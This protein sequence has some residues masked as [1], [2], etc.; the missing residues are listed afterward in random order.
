MA[1]FRVI[2][3]C[4]RTSRPGAVQQ[5]T[6]SAVLALLLTCAGCA[7]PSTPLSPHRAG[8]S[9]TFLYVANRLSH[10]VTEYHLDPANGTLTLLG[11]IATGAYPMALVVA[12]QQHALYV[13][14][15]GSDSVS[16][17]HI[18]P[19]GELTPFGV[20]QIAAGKNPARSTGW[21]RYRRA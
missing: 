14:N 21:G 15:E 9:H 3:V 8:Q 6:W 17:Y 18:R 4:N 16:Q 11:H 20:P 1:L 10:D 13:A 12:P 19:D 2:A 7:G 5:R